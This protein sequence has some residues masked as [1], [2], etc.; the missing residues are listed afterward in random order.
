MFGMI[1]AGLGILSIGLTLST[2]LVDGMTEEE[3][4]KQQQMEEDFDHYQENKKQELE[5]IIHEHNITKEEFIYSH[6]E[7]IVKLRVEHE[8]Q[9]NNEKIHFIQNIQNIVNEQLLAKEELKY[10]IDEHI[11]NIKKLRKEQK[12][13]LRGEAI[14]TLQRELEEAKSK[15]FAYKDY[16][17]SYNSY[18]KG[19]LRSS[20]EIDEDFIMFSFV[21]PKEYPYRGKLMFMDKK[22]LMK[23]QFINNIDG[24]VNVGYSFEE[25]YLIEDLDDNT[26]VP[27]LVS[28]SGFDRNNYRSVYSLSAAK[29]YI[30]HIAIDQRRIGIEAKVVEHVFEKTDRYTKQYIKLDYKGITLKLNKRDLE[31]PNRTPPCGTSIRVYP[32]K[33]DYALMYDIEVSQKYQDSLKAFNFSD[34]P[35]VFNEESALEFEEYVTSNE[36]FFEGD[37]WKIGPLS[38]EQIPNVTEIKLQ[39]G[40]ELVF[41]ARVENNEKPYFIFKEI[42]EKKDALKPDD[43]FVVMEATLNCIFEEE[44]DE[45]EEDTFENMANLAI[46]VSN[47]FKLQKGIKN[48]HDGMTYFNKWAEITDKLINYLYKGKSI[49]CDVDEVVYSR[50][51]RNNMVISKA[52][53]L[54]AEQVREYIEEVSSGFRT[55]FFLENKDNEYITVEFS[56]TAEMMYISGH[57][58]LDLD[59]SMINVYAKNF[60]YPEVQQKRALNDF[61]SGMLSN[62]KLQSYILNSAN[63]ESNLHENLDIEFINK[64]LMNNKAQKDSVEKALKEKDIFL[65]QGPPGTGKTTVIREIINQH[66]KYHRNDRILIVSQANVAIDNVLKG[67]DKSLMDDMIRCGHEEKID[68]ELKSISFE[69]KYRDYIEKINKKEETLENSHLLN[70][71]KNIVNKSYGKYNA[72]VGELILK[73]HSIIGATCVG[74]AQKQIGLDRLEFD[75]V[76]IDEV[77]KA[78]PAEILIPL[79]RAKKVI[80]IGDHKQLP[81]TVH[82]ALYDTDKIELDDKEY[83]QDELFEKCLFENLYEMCPNTNKSMLRTQ[84]RMPSVIGSMISECFYENKLENGEPTYNKKSI[85]LESNLNILDMSKDK[86]FVENQEGNSSVTNE[87]ESKVVCQVI[88]DIRKEIGVEKRIAVISPYK[89][90]KRVILKALRNEGI[91][92]FENNIAVNTIDAF[93]GDEAE[94]VLYCTTRSKRPTKYFSDLARLNVAFSRAKNELIIIGSLDYFDKYGEDHILHKISDYIRKE[95][96]IIDYMKSKYNEEYKVSIRHKRTRTKLEKEE[97]TVSDMNEEFKIVS[98]SK[99]IIP[100]DFKLTPPARNKVENFI[101]YYKIHKKFDKHINVDE[102]LKLKNGYARYIAAKELGLNLVSVK[103]DMHIDSK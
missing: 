21:L 48:S 23:Y 36:L 2:F 38:E 44:L 68:E 91:N 63:I 71:W 77:G 10:E 80:M 26:M 100:E 55:E 17:K 9:Q 99:I 19:Y 41:T 79:N 95:G 33:W 37:E 39:Y 69:L 56:P 72:N 28:E 13:L 70:R 29:G 11:R 22:D 15:V 7:E 43:I 66:I 62:G 102:N 51:D 1:A 75:L 5:R 35:L 87:R 86:L 53:I 12:S 3:R 85:Y 101:N 25:D 34:I 67:M 54:N 18:L 83:C 49:I 103:I 6:E 61:R 27:V 78:L 47:E 59:T 52:N 88:K 50:R 82:T 98:L 97:N 90:Q 94:I 96:N 8:Q 14:N 20:K 60:S 31:N 84:Y 81:P 65:I 92:I 73:R 30:K 4:Y 40:N 74:L 64:N 16:L 24:V 93:Q 46:M 42:L 32:K 89:G 58:K 45:L 76:I 57:H